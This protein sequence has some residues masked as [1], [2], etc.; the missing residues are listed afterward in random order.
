MTNAETSGPST[1]GLLRTPVARG[2]VIVAL[3]CAK[4]QLAR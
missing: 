1:M 4:L 2:V 3:P